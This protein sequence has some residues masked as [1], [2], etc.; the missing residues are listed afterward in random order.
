[1]KR[2]LRE[3]ARE[4]RRNGVAI[5]EIAKTLH[6]SKGS[7]SDWVRDIELTEEQKSRLRQQK[8][9]WEGQNKGAQANRRIFREKRLQYQEEGRKKAR[10]CSALHLAGCMLYW[11]EGAKQRNSVYFVNSDV[12]MMKLFVRFLRQELSV[13]DDD[14][15]IV[16][17]CYQPEDVEKVRRYWIGQLQLSESALL[18]TQIKKGSEIRK[19]ILVNGLCGIRVSDTRLIQHIYGAIQE[20]GGFDNPAW[21]F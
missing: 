13:L 5:T 9:R 17:L 16:T 8:G 11:A 6:V 7:V 3:Q 21:L 12:N 14:M 10:E 2:Q 1:M 4:L 19:N 18:T 20:Y 15:S